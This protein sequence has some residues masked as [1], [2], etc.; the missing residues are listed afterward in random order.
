MGNDFFI[1]KGTNNAE[2][3]QSCNWVFFEFANAV[4][5]INFVGVVFLY[6]FSL[7]EII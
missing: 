1:I 4:K 2:D 5:Q 6:N 7:K 3:V